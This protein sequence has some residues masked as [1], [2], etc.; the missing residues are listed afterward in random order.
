MPINTAWILL[1]VLALVRLT[2]IVYV[3]LVSGRVA[4]VRGKEGRRSQCV[5]VEGEPPN[6]ARATNSVRNQL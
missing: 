1:A 4:A 5:I 6:F 2:V 3:A